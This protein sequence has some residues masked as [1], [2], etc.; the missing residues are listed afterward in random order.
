MQRAWIIIGSLITVAALGFGTLNVV[1]LLAHE[2]VTETATFDG[3]AVEVVDIGTDN[4]SIEIVGGTGDEIRLV[5]EISHGIRRTSHRAAVDGSTLVVRSSCPILSSWCHVDYR[6][7]VP[8]EVAL[9]ARIDN[10]RLTVRDLDGGVDVDGD[11][12][13]IELTRLSGSVTASTDNGRL[14]ATGLRS[15]TVLADSDNGRVSLGFAEPPS[16]VQATTDNGSVEIVL[17]VGSES[18]RV[19]VDTHHGSTDV[20]VRTDPSSDRVIVGRTNNGSVTVRY[21]TG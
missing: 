15:G 18:Y 11:N 16:T 20:G 2:E 17:P 14:V 12:G 3:S 8:A 5:V 21:P 10:G 1:G 6:L 19:D 9:V 13:S 4:G 7:E